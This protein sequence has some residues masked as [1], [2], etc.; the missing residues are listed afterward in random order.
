MAESYV[1]ID[2]PSLDNADRCAFLVNDSFKYVVAGQGS[3]V[4]QF[5]LYEKFLSSNELNR[6]TDLSDL[7]RTDFIPGKVASNSEST[8]IGGD[9][10]LGNTCI[11]N[12]KNFKV[13]R[14]TGFKFRLYKKGEITTANRTESF[15]HSLVDDYNEVAQ[16]V[17]IY[18]PTFDETGKTLST[19][20]RIAYARY[21]TRDTDGSGIYIIEDPG[22]IEIP[23]QWLTTNNCSIVISFL[24]TVNSSSLESGDFGQSNTSIRVPNGYTVGLR[25]LPRPAS[26][27]TSY[28]CYTTSTAGERDAGE[29]RLLDFD[30]FI[31]VDLVEEF[32]GSNSTNHHLNVADVKDLNSLRYS[33]PA[34]LPDASYTKKICTTKWKSL[35]Y[36]RISDKSITRNGKFEL[37]DKVIN[38]VQIPFTYSEDAENYI[39]SNTNYGNSGDIKSGNGIA[40]TNRKLLI[41][42]DTD[43]EGTPMWV[44]SDNSLCF[45]YFPGALNYIFTFNGVKTDLLKYKGKGIWIAAR[46]PAGEKGQSNLA[47]NAWYNADED[48]FWAYA[49]GDNLTDDANC[50][51]I[52]F[53]DNLRKNA[54]PNIKIMFSYFNRLEWFD[55]I[56]SMAHECNSSNNL[57]A[58]SI[59][60]GDWRIAVN[61]EGHLEI[62]HNTAT[63]AADKSI[64]YIPGTSNR[65]SI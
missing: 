14:L 5:P 51:Y 38:S 54:T 63:T 48:K 15:E 1:Y 6:M 37:E 52:D 26:D 56:E 55:Y 45:S 4:A 39:S 42:F 34:I 59:N 36:I 3:D 19:W 22:Y 27:N 60:L 13:G 9:Y 33:A 64:F 21:I 7:M 58:D 16:R 49:K 28:I 62:Y 17:A 57:S 29:S 41:A 32:I 8:T 31:D 46:P 50:D 10:A 20:K 24:Q 23:G 11:I 40:N 44:E 47:F 65:T 43:E 18:G 53:S 30:Y 61:P 25:G 35:S 2:A 12:A